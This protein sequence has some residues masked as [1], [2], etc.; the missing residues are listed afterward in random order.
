[1]AK[2]EESIFAFAS[3]ITPN[4]LGNCLQRNPLSAS[5]RRLRQRPAHSCLGGNG[6]KSLHYEVWRSLY[7]LLARRFFS[8]IQL[9]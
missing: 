4:P 5:W 3:T 7:K 9:Y 1:M 6:S 2:R 8:S